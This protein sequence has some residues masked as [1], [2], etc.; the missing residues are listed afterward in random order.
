MYLS[1]C[2]GFTSVLEV[3]LICRPITAQWD[4]DVTGLCGNQTA[5]FVTIEIIGLV[6]DLAILLSPLPTLLHSAMDC[7]SKVRLIILLDAGAMYVNAER[8]I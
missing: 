2:H 5:S 8:D 7:A 1:I 3:C 4:P 6:L